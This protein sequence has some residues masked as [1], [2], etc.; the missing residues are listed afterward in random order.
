MSLGDPRIL[1]ARETP[2]RTRDNSLPYF[3]QLFAVLSQTLCRTRIRLRQRVCLST[4]KSPVPDGKE[5]HGLAQRNVLTRSRYCTAQ[6]IDRKGPEARPKSANRRTD[7]GQSL[8]LVIVAQ[9]KRR[10]C[11][12]FGDKGVFK[13][14]LSL[15]ENRWGVAN[16]GRRRSA[17][18]EVPRERKRKLMVTSRICNILRCRAKISREIELVDAVARVRYI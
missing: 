10:L 8:S 1:T 11:L 17:A 18:R 3:H 15:D 13:A 7:K 14:V 9:A 4:A 5:S 6:P 12:P 2:C 16:A